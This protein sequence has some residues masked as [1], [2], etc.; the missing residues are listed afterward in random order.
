MAFVP[1]S[2][3]AHISVRCLT[4][5]DWPRSGDLD[6]GPAAS[7]L[8]GRGIWGVPRRRSPGRGG[9]RTPRG[10]GWL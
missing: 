8:Q 2:N 1:D 9:G 3:N 7:L 10:G 4:L 6:D 5:W